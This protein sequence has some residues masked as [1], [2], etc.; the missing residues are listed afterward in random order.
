MIR[1][2]DSRND[3][4]ILALK[5]LHGHFGES[6]RLR[7]QLARGVQV[8]QY[9]YRLLE[10]EQLSPHVRRANN[11]YQHITRQGKLTFS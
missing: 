5:A 4:I 6:G 11:H 9:T 1:V 2:P 7:I 8:A 3:D 10:T